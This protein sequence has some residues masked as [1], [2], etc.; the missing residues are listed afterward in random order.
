[1]IN[2]INQQNI[3]EELKKLL[4]IIYDNGPVDGRTMEDLAFI[5]RYYPSLFHPYEKTLLFLMGLFYKT[6]SPDSLFTEALNI[7]REGIKDTYGK[8]YTPDQ[9]IITKSIQESLYYSFSS[10]T[11]SGK[12]YLFRDLIL[13]AK[14]DIVVIVP[15]RALIS[16]Y[17]LT[18]TTFVPKEVLILTFVDNINK[19]K[20][21]RRVFILTPERARE[22]FRYK[23]IF[24]IEMFLFDEAQLTD[25][26]IRGLKFDALVRRIIREFPKAKKVFAH[27]FIKNPEAQFQKHSLIENCASNSFKEYSVGQLFYY[28]EY[29]NYYLYSPYECVKSIIPVKQDNQI[30]ANTITNGGTVLVYTAKTK[31]YKMEFLHDFGSLIDLLPNIIDHN[32]L[33]I[34]DELRKYLGASKHGRRHSLLIDM[35]QKG[36]VLHHGSIPLKGR[37]LI[38]KF[39]NCGYARLCFATATLL[40]GVNMPFDVVYIDNF[41]NLSAIDFKNLIGRAGRTDSTDNLN[42]GSIICEKNKVKKLISRLHEECTLDDSNKL[43]NEVSSYYDDDKDL[44]EAIQ[45]DEFLDDLN[46]PK[47]Q[48]ERINA[49][50]DLPATIRE[51]IDL[52]MPNGYPLS[53]EDYREAASSTRN[54]IKHCFKN[55]YIAGLRNKNLTSAENKVISTALQILLWRIQRKSFSETV[56]M[57]Y[58]YLTHAKERRELSRLLKEGKIDKETYE[59]NL[60]S[61]KIIYS[62]AAFT[63]PNKTLK[64]VPLFAAET[65]IKL[66]SYD[67]LVYDTY[68]YLDKV[69]SLSLVDP[70]NAALEAYYT[71]EKDIRAK[72]LQNYIRFG[73]NSCFEIMLLRYGFDFEDHTWLKQCIDE[74]NE[75]GIKFNSNV[76]NL[77]EEQFSLIERYI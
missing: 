9:S 43:D 21:D 22:L 68:D 4:A 65:S 25:E 44:V 57:R 30:I 63:L 13:N 37:V 52:L 58:N 11:S 3:E 24:T 54:R 17:Y 47:I 49:Q 6:N 70:I 28:R 7:F 27:P 15:S 56:Q 41:R 8:Y 53:G 33:K 76:K 1:M 45:K 34:I 18:L 48:Y 77:S 66:C 29:N 32:A 71:K 50:D 69:I 20:T 67:L 38:E 19:A 2:N 75:D 26:D 12:S 60:S 46:I 40:R 61:L 31:I 42:I 62:P 36:I 14:K 59:Y 23:A 51:L 10:P 39:I 5:K 73:T 16:E 74:I 64:A 72:A 35:M 55:V